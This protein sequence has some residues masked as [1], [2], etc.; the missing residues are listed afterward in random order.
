MRTVEEIM[1]DLKI[2]EDALEACKEAGFSTACVARDLSELREELN[3]AL[4]AD[5]K[6][7]INHVCLWASSTDINEAVDTL[8]KMTSERTKKGYAFL[9]GV[10][11][12]VDNGTYHVMQTLFKKE[13]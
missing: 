1:Q 12:S 8:Q 4:K 9:G 6:Q 10:S 2:A 7:I 3:D 11:L 13:D 5:H